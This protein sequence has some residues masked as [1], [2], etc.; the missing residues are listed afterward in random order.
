MEK[1][2]FTLIVI[3]SFLL[4]QLQNPKVE[5]IME[6]L[7]RINS[8]YDLAF[9]DIVAKVNRGKYWSRPLALHVESS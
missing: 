1:A 5:K 7:K 8:S 3:L 4:A 9:S 6:I 2:C